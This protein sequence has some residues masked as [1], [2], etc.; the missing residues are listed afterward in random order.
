MKIK[1][2]SFDVYEAGENTLCNAKGVCYCAAGS[3]DFFTLLALIYIIQQSLLFLPGTL[4]T[5]FAGDRKQFMADLPSHI[6]S[7][8][9]W[10]LSQTLMAVPVLL[11]CS[12]VRRASG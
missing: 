5:L 9:A 8:L 11:I 6:Y 10:F 2:H 7:P 1:P 4:T 3:I 12:T